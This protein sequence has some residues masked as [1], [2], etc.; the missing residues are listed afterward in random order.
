MYF[1]RSITL[2]SIVALTSVV[3]GRSLNITNG[4]DSW[5][6]GVYVANDTD[7]YCCVSGKLQLSVCAGWP[8]CTG[9]TT[10]D[11]KTS[12]LSCATTVPVTAS[13]Y[14]EAISRAS[15][16]YYNTKHSNSPAIATKT[17]AAATTSTATGGAGRLAATLLPA[18]GGLLAI[19][20]MGN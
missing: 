11:P 15:A 9:S 6:P 14:K 20:A 16:S 12:T 4:D 10:I 7:A 8:L 17:Q 13:D 3:Q 1:I 5:C 18:C 19:A 2:L